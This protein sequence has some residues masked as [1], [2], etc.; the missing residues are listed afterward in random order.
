MAKQLDLKLLKSTIL[1]GIFLA[2]KKEFRRIRFYKPGDFQNTHD[3]A[4][5]HT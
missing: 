2:E 5:S 1:N 4:A 3:I